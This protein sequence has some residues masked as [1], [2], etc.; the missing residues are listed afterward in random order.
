MDAK[1]L[2]ELINE[3]IDKKINKFYKTVIKPDVEKMIAEAIESID[4]QE[5]DLISDGVGI[6]SDD[7]IES[8]SGGLMSMMESEV[9]RPKTKPNIKPL[10]QTT[11]TSKKKFN[12]GNNALNGILNEMAKDPSKYRV[13]GDNDMSS[14]NALMQQ[15]YKS[16]ENENADWPDM[17]YNISPGSGIPTPILPGIDGTSSRYLDSVKQEVFS[18]TGGN[19][20]ITNLLVKDYRQILKKAEEKARG[21][22]GG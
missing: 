21:N 22:R 15:Q 18:Q 8:N 14:Y 3:L 9:E 5:E 4:V 2:V 1:Q 6:E 10:G 12:V 19:A 16:D 20:E 7:I 13:A 11:Q 17:K